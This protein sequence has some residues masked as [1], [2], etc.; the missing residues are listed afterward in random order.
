MAQQIRSSY[1]PAVRIERRGRDGHLSDRSGHIE[2]MAYREA[3]RLD[4][5]N[6]AVYHDHLGPALSG[7]GRG[8]LRRRPPSGR[9]PGWIQGRHAEAEV[10]QKGAIRLDPR[11]APLPRSPRR[12]LV[13]RTGTPRP[14][15][16]GVSGDGLG[17]STA[18]FL[19]LPL[20]GF[21]AVG[22]ATLTP[23]D[24]TETCG[25][26]WNV[27]QVQ[28]PRWAVLDMCSLLRILP[29]PLCSRSGGHDGRHEPAG[30]EA[31]LCTYLCT[32]RGGTC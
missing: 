1:A 29:A 24:P 19:C 27:G 30:W 7:Q 26:L 4:P 21:G 14:R 10:A 22:P 2:G 6:A 12:A 15:Q 20:I 25:R 11:N 17:L 18:K 23:P 16:P 5:G 3:I 13:S 31:D 28:G 9:R 8:R 32:R